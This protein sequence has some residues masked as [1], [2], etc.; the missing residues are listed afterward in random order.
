L[1]QSSEYWDELEQFLRPH[2]ELHWIQLIH[3]NRYE[4]AFDV[5][6]SLAQSECNSAQRKKT[7]LSLAKISGLASG[8]YNESE[9]TFFEHFF[10][11]CFLGL[12][13]TSD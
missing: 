8:K 11:S 3:M 12:V 2:P 4:E 13:S 5:L 6:L 9:S 1:E 7:L 10:R